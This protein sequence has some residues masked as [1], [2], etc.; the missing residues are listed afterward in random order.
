MEYHIVTHRLLAPTGALIVM[1]V[2]YL[3][4]ATF[5]DFRIDAIDV[6]NVTLSRLNSINALMSQD[7]D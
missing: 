7:A 1:M 5:S 3:S 4:A 6:T 2:Y